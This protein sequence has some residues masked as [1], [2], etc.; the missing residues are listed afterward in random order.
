[1]KKVTLLLL[2]GI[3]LIPASTFAFRMGGCAA[4][5]LTI[6]GGVRALALG[7]AYS[8]FAEGVEAIYWNPAGIAKLKNIGADFV[9]ANLFPGAGI[10]VN[11]I[12]AVVPLGD[13]TIG[14]SAIALLSGDIPYTPETGEQSVQLYYS[15]NSFAA[16]LSYAR[17]MTDKFNAGITFKLINQ[18]IALPGTGLTSPG[19]AF[20]V[21]GTYNTKLNGLQFGFM[22]QNFGR[23]VAFGGEALQ[24][25]MAETD[26]QDAD[27][28]YTELAQGDPLP[29]S[30][31]FGGAMD[32][33]SAPGYKITI[34]SDLMN[35][36]DQPTTYGIGMEASIDNSYFAR[37]GYTEKNSGG[38]TA[39]IGINTKLMGT[40]NISV[41]YTYQVHTEG[42]AGIHRIGL[43]FRI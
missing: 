14:V 29:L 26:L 11:N 22:I 12:A 43:G 27:I 34:M 15:A 28:K 33:V 24:G 38:L 4:P 16:G 18:Y 3:L 2:V 31:Q 7:G 36:L 23:D 42:L 25:M 17:R 10:S 30:F 39:G 35:V 6:G 19:W 1:M 41:D 8:A 21:G 37:L 9:Y 40:R 5:F 32:V 13:G 20:D